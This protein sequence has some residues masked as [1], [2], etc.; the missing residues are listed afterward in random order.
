M[1]IRFAFEDI[2]SFGR[3][4]TRRR[5]EQHLAILHAQATNQLRKLE[6]QEETRIGED[7][8]Q[9]LCHA[10]GYT[11]ALLVT[12]ASVEDLHLAAYDEKEEDNAQGAG[13]MPQCE[14]E[15]LHARWVPRGRKDA[16]AHRNRNRNRSRDHLRSLKCNRPKR[17][18]RR[19]PAEVQDRETMFAQK[20]VEKGLYSDVSAARDFVRECLERQRQRDALIWA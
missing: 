12:S 13:C 4:S 2:C 14:L 11:P 20:L 17:S 16:L 10:N 3:A 9:I 5:A 6:E 7:Q 18:K 19:R 15:Y 8:I 1:S